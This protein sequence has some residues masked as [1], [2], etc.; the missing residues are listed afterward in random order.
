MS[1]SFTFSSNGSSSGLV[2]FVEDHCT[3]GENSLTQ[4]M[5]DLHNQKFCSHD[6][7]VG[8][9]CG[10]L[11]ILCTCK[12]L[13]IFVH[14]T[15]MSMSVP[16]MSSTSSIVPS[17][18][19]ST[20]LSTGIPPVFSIAPQPPSS[21]PQYFV[22]AIGGGGALLASAIFVIS[23]ICCAWCCKKRKNRRRNAQNSRNAQ[24]ELRQRENRINGNGTLCS[25]GE[26][27]IADVKETDWKRQYE[28][29]SPSGLSSYEDSVSVSEGALPSFTCNGQELSGR[30]HQDDEQLEFMSMPVGKEG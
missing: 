16:L 6:H 23:V 30:S 18:S 27:S 29:S 13:T 25:S 1:T 9:T 20:T 19:P 5:L 11:Y 7:D 15:A 22:Y 4:C 3:V 26:T 10:K 2:F 28:K 8:L 17:P 24:L 21:L 12:K 14:F